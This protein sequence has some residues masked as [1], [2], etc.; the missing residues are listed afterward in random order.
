MLWFCLR[1]V[2]FG[3]SN[4]E[5]SFFFSS[6]NFIAN[7][8]L[9]LKK[10]N[11]LLYPEWRDC[12]CP[13]RLLTIVPRLRTGQHPVP[14]TPASRSSAASSCG[15]RTLPP[16]RSSTPWWT[17]RRSGRL[18]T[19]PPGR[20]T[21]WLWWTLCCV[22][23]GWTSSPTGTSGGSSASSG[24]TLSSWKPGQVPPTG[25]PSYPEINNILYR[26]RK[27]GRANT[28]WELNQLW[29]Y[30]KRRCFVSWR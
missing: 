5:Y 20:C 26:D 28:S 18:R 10:Q 17:T 13:N 12:I 8:M 15:T 4:Y 24:P 9:C 6:S 22:A 25:S 14:S 16:G 19:R 29:P 30:C 3:G 21:R 1:F 2:R 7:C 11:W 27:R 23:W